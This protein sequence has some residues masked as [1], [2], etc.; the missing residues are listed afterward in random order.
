MREKPSASGIRDKILDPLRN[1]KHEV[2]EV[3]EWDSAKVIVRALSAGDWL[4]Y[5]HRALQQ[6]EAARIAAGL[7]PHAEEG[8]SDPALDI[9][10]TPLYAFVMAR[11]L[12]EPP[13][14]RIFTDDDVPE[15]TEAYSPVHDR[16]VARAL[17]LSGVALETDPVDTAGNG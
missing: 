4:E 16:L 6:V 10:S 17:E 2:M 9:F 11:T 14:Q 1:F 15:L 3:P 5:R 7:S 12:F 8:Q 13:G